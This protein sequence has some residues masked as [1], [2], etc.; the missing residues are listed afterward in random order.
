MKASAIL[1]TNKVYLHRRFSRRPIKNLF[2]PSPNNN[3]FI[4]ILSCL[5]SWL[6]QCLRLVWSH[7]SSKHRANIRT[8]ISIRSSPINNRLIRTVGIN[9]DRT[10]ITV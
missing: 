6:L 4:H 7:L 9:E 3:Y 2:K 10:V 1:D 5:I 8:L